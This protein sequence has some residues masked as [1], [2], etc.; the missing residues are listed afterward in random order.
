[1]SK[2]WLSKKLVNNVYQTDEVNQEADYI[3]I[4]I[5]LAHMAL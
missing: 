3:I 1:M 5:I 2:T 4:N